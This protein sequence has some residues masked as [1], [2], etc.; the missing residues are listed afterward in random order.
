MMIKIQMLMLSAVFSFLATPL[1]AHADNKQDPLQSYRDEIKRM[2][3]N[4]SQTVLD[5]LKANESNAP[6]NS[7][8]RQ[9]AP[10]PLPQSPISNNDKAFSPPTA[11]QNNAAP[12]SSNDNNPWLKPNP[13]EAQ[14]HVNP[15]ANAPIPSAGSTTAPIAP[16]PPPPNI[17]APPHPTVSAPNKTT[18][19]NP[20]R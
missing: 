3:A 20:N 15:W 13:W 6:S 16:P 14:A 11:T 5:Q 18:N 19:N 12:K 2:E 4:A 10:A 1:V 8:P 7:I 17:F 9:S